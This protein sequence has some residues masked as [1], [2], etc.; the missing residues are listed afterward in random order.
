MIKIS[1]LLIIISINI[2]AETMQEI[3]DKVKQ[4]YEK[5]DLG[6]KNII[7]KINKDNNFILEQKSW[8]ENKNIE[9]DEIY[10][11]NKNGSIA[12]SEYYNCLIKWNKNRISELKK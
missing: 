9:C 12:S 2:L 10:E 6:L 7:N 5:S 11:E 3:E 1:I 8:E 4:E